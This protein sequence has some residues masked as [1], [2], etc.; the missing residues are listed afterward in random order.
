M[1][2]P[3]LTLQKGAQTDAHSH[4][5]WKHEGTAFL[6][7]LNAK[8]T[9]SSRAKQQSF[10]SQSITQLEPIPSE[11]ITSESTADIRT[12]YLLPAPQ[13]DTTRYTS[14]GEQ[15]RVTPAGP[16]VC[17]GL[18]LPP[19][20][21]T[22]R[23]HGAA[24]ACAD[25]SAPRRQPRAAPSRSQRRTAGTPEPRADKTAESAALSRYVKRG[26]QIPKP[27][28]PAAEPFHRCRS[29]LSGPATLPPPG[30]ARRGAGALPG[31][32][33]PLELTGSLRSRA[34]RPEPP[35]RRPPRSALTRPA[36][37]GPGPARAPLVR[38]T[39]AWNVWLRVLPGALRGGL[40]PPAE[41]P[42]HTRRPAAAETALTLWETRQQNPN[43][44]ALT[45]T[46]SWGQH[47]EAYSPLPSSIKRRWVYS[48]CIRT[49]EQ[50]N[51]IPNKVMQK[52]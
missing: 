49:N 36:P 43:E 41:A 28:Q 35:A 34:R 25:R 48:S 39:P 10:I 38:S 44:A 21:V 31:A 13:R 17:V 12:P 50:H 30:P 26:S 1:P 7:P 27:M 45:S 6:L 29:P 11:R 3:G 15:S 16:H 51:P 22:A 32:A 40:P 5:R 9:G 37:P 4:K 20:R 14:R 2:F 33:A 8:T 42:R 52:A 24:A 19:R 23:A 47:Q 46:S 18:P